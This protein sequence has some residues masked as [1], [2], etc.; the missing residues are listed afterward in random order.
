MGSDREMEQLLG[1]LREFVRN[2]NETISTE[3]KKA[4]TDGA[5]PP[6]PPRP[7]AQGF[8]G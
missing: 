7:A 1:Q 3:Y 8:S 6:P 2:S 4:D 5:P